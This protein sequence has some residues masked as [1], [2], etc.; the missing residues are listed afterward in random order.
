MF[1]FNLSFQTAEIKLVA[2]KPV[3][4]NESGLSSKKIL[5]H[6]GHQV[7]S[8]ENGKEAMILFYQYPFDLI[9][10]DCQMPEMDGFQT[11]RAIREA[12]KKSG[13]HLAKQP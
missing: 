10:M 12:E 11:T 4:K 7:R 5:A 2:L 13:R 8:A 6:L 9:L 3:I 1:W